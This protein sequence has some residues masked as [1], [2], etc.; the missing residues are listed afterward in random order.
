VIGAHLTTCGCNASG[1]GLGFSQFHREGLRML[2]ASLKLTQANYPEDLCQTY[3][4]N[5]PRIFN[6]VWKVSHESV[7]ALQ[8][9]I[10]AGSRIFFLCVYHCAI[11]RGRY[12][13]W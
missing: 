12:Y 9:T 7:P 11:V 10:P 6:M 1:Q 5:A 4:I 2:S 8:A 13:R 3:I